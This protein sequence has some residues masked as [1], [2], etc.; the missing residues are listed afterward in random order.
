MDEECII[1]FEVMDEKNTFFKFACS[2]SE[3]MHERCIAK[4]DKCPLTAI[5]PTP[6]PPPPCG[7]QKVL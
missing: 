1:C 4:L 7:I 2:H 3:I 5:G 6:G